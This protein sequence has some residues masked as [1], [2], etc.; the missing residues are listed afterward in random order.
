MTLTPPVVD[1][2]R[3]RV[4][5]ITGADKADAVAALDRGTAGGGLP[6]ERVPAAGTTVVLD[7]AA[8]S[9]LT[10]TSAAGA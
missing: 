7:A 10:M 4:V 5:L 1:A 6:I 2:A 8:A 9:L 3:A